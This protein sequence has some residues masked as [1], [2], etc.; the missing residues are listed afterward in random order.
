MHPEGHSQ[1]LKIVV[2]NPSHPGHQHHR[3]ASHEWE[4]VGKKKG[5][6]EL[7]RDCK[8]SKGDLMD[9]FLQKFSG[10]VT[11]IFQLWWLFCPP[12]L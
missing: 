7:S 11:A 5:A 6:P 10:I 8:L 1:V 12:G 4:D 3:R 2:G 9:C